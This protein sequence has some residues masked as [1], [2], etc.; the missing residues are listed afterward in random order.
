MEVRRL[1]RELAQ[2]QIAELNRIYRGGE[3]SDAVRRIVQRELDI[4]AERFKP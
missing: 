4:E 3:V 1:R 2:L